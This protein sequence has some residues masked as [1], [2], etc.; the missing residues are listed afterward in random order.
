MALQCQTPSQQNGCRFNLPNR[1]T[2]IIAESPQSFTVSFSVKFADIKQEFRFQLS[3]TD[4]G[5]ELPPWNISVPIKAS[6]YSVGEWVTIEIPVS[7]LT[8]SGAWSNKANKW[9]NP[10]GRFDWSRLDSIYF[11]FDDFDNKN[12]GDIYIDDIVIKNK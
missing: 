10:Q 11:D 5:A 1:I 9:F 4:E 6:D 12:K 3:D 7:K 2:S 8:E